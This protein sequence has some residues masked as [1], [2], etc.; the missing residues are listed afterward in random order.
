MYL[1]LPEFAMRIVAPLLTLLTLLAFAPLAVLSD[2]SPSAS[3]SPTPRPVPTP[4]ATVHIQNSAFVPQ[5]V[6]IRAGQSVMFVNDDIFSHTVTA[7]NKSYDSGDLAKG[8][9]W[10]HTFTA[11]GTSTYTCT[12]H[13]FMRGS[14]SVTL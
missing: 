3:P 5:T 13:P 6:Q 12:Y 14:V 1:R 9:S 11:V 8:R 2:P 4:A 10:T 7:D